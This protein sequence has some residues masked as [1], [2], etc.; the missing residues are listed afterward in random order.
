LWNSLFG[1]LKLRQLLPPIAIIL[2]MTGVL[3]SGQT[4]AALLSYQR[5]F[6]LEGEIW[7][8][9]TSHLVHTGVN[10]LILNSTGLILV[11][12]LFG[13]LFS[14]TFWMKGILVLMA[15]ISLCQ[16]AFYPALE[17]YV[18]FSGVLHGLW[19]VGSVGA[20]ARKWHLGWISLVMIA[21]KL[22]AEQYFGP[23]P[24]T[25]RLIQSPIF[26]DAHFYGAIAGGGIGLLGIFSHGR[27]FPGNC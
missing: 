22:L 14:G 10:H 11:F 18:G 21:G 9:F 15:A 27:C 23:S 6:V 24:G 2:V 17:T 20:I 3:L 5:S 12:W 19:A 13:P 25:E 7:R 8:L 16:L 1:F 4:G 26:I